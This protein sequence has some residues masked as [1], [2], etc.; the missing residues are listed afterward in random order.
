MEPVAT[1]G[2]ATQA[3]LKQ[4]SASCKARAWSGCLQVS[5]SYLQMLCCAFFFAFASTAQHQHQHSKGGSVAER[6]ATISSGL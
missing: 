4:G 5:C 1:R 2:L 3:L 6:V